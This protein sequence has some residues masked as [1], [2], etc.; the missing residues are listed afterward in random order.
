MEKKT[1]VVDFFVK[2]WLTVAI[3]KGGPLP[4]EAWHA[5][6]SYG[7]IVPLLLPDDASKDEKW[8]LTQFYKENPS[9]FPNHRLEDPKEL[10]TVYKE[11]QTAL[12]KLLAEQKNHGAVIRTAYFKLMKEGYPIPGTPL[13]DSQTLRMKSTK[14]EWQESTW[15]GTVFPMS[16]S[17]EY[18]QIMS[19]QQTSRFLES[20][21]EHQL[22][23]DE[24]LT[25]IDQRGREAR[26]R[27][28]MLPRLVALVSSQL[29][30][31]RLV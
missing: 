8:T 29:E 17:C 25:L 22:D 4:K 16:C 31:I 12:E 21:A 9:A 14:K 27:D 18:R 7:T 19:L 6:F 30:V 20:P 23:D 28:F 15:F 10:E 13:A 5:I 11:N 3:E 2:D 24:M 1:D 26:R